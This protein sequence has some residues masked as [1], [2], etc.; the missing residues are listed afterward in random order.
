MQRK[1]PPAAIS[2]SGFNW[3]WYHLPPTSHLDQGRLKTKKDKAQKKSELHTATGFGNHFKTKCLCLYISIAP[4]TNSDFKSPAQRNCA[5][6]SMCEDTQP[7][8]AFAGSV[9]K[10]KLRASAIQESSFSNNLN[11]P[12][13]YKSP[14]VLFSAYNPGAGKTRSGSDLKNLRSQ[15]YNKPASQTASYAPAEPWDFPLWKFPPILNPTTGTKARE[16]S[17]YSKSASIKPASFQ[18]RQPPPVYLLLHR[19]STMLQAV[20]KC[21]EKLVVMGGFSRCPHFSWVKE[22]ISSLCSYFYHGLCYPSLNTIYL[23]L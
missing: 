18:F 22:N 8:S 10:A 20:G 11:A 5:S 19:D 14:R 17:K 2:I 15:P 4:V 1:W 7:S 16:I 21:S 9:F 6:L 13:I 12:G 3:L 23:C